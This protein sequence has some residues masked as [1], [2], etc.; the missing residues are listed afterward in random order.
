[1]SALAKFALLAVVFVDLIGQ[2]LVFPIINTLMMDPQQTFL[3]A[4]T[5]EATREFDY[6]L[7]IGIFFLSWFLGAAYISRLSDSIGRKNAIMIC[8]AGALV[9]YLITIVSLFLNSLWLLVLG[10]AITGFTAGNQ[11]IAQ[12]AMVDASRDDAEKGR[13]MGFIV[14]GISAGLV[15][16]PVI[17]GILSDKS[18]IGDAASIKLPFYCAVVLVLITIVLV[19]LFFRDVREHKKALSIQPL[20]IFRSLWRILDYP[21]VLRISLVFFFFQWANVTFYIFMDNYL[22]DR[23]QTS[24]FG[25]SMAMMV[26]G[27]A[28]AS[29]STLFVGPVQKRFT[30]IAIVAGMICTMI[31]CSLLYVLAPHPLYCYALI[32]VYYFGFGIAYPTI[33]GIYSAS[34]DDNEQ[35]WVMGITVALFT[36]AA[37]ITSFLGGELTSID[38]DSPFYVSSGAA[39]AALI[40]LFTV[41][42]QPDIRRI[43]L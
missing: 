16:G 35:G 23:F 28:L 4:S 37:G 39:V 6:G 12:A 1:M 32:F 18:L 36:L 3:P 40:L 20:D 14:A 11:P 31:I 17:G 8:L 22:T 42:N 10:R 9:G 27:V 24:L 19:Q 26:L 25:T 2:G 34:V 5:P 43:T 30:K 15:G 33:L 29:S 7:V 21:I 38:I 41:W 13:N